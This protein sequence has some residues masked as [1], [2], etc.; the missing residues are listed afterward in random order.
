MQQ[1]T[2]GSLF[3]LV[4]VLS[5]AIIIAA[6]ANAK[7]TFF[8]VLCIC[9]LQ[10]ISKCKDTKK[11]WIGGKKLAKQKHPHCAEWDSNVL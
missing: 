9:I 3:C 4:V 2:H 8:I 7:N 5:P 10:S 1:F 6:A 11:N